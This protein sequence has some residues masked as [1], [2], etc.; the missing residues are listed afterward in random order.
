MYSII[1]IFVLTVMKVALFTN[2]RDED[3]ILEWVVHHI[4]LGFDHIYIIDHLSEIPLKTVL[5]KLPS[6][7]VTTVRV[8]EPIINKNIF[9]IQAYEA[10][11]QTVDWDWMLYLDCD[12]FLI[13]N[14]DNSVQDFLKRYNYYNQLSVNWLCFGTN[15][16]DSFQGTIMEN[17]TKCQ[18]SLNPLVKS[19]INIRS[20]ARVD[21]IITPHSYQLNNTEKTI[22]VDYHLTNED[23]LYKNNMPIQ[24][25]PAYIAHYEYQ[26]YETYIRRKIR[27]P[28]DDLCGY[29]EQIPKEELDKLNN[30]IDNYFP[31]DKYN[32]NNKK[33]IELYKV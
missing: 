4:G 27:I 10:L 31:R 19:F 14:Y 16:K 17:F 9:M 7:R 18:T 21:K 29:R 20:P 26:S 8:D 24:A 25:C 13:L 6:E 30:D 32:E 15:Y 5:Q 1:I 23:A 2:A 3:N 22:G 12:E 28:R 33:L 11:K